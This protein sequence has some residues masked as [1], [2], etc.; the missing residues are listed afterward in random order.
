[1][2]TEE[3][4]FWT[5]DPLLRQ[6]REELMPKQ[7]GIDSLRN[8]RGAGVLFDNLA[9]APCRVGLAAVGFKEVGRPALLLA[10][11]VLGQFPAEAARK[12]DRALFVAF[13]LAHADLTGLQIDIGGAEV[14]E[15]SI[16]HAREEQQF[17]HDGVRE[18]AR[19]PDRIVERGQFGVCEEGGQPFRCRSST[20]VQERAGV[21]KDLFEVM[22]V[23]MV[24][25]QHPHQLL[26]HRFGR[27]TGGH[28]AASRKDGWSRSSAKS[29]YGLTCS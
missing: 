19:L 20:D 26:G 22:I 25:T 5:D 7:M 16:A 8:P 2:P 27:D 14:D 13:A 3:L 11:Q 28:H 18:L 6:I 4:E 12:E 10:L 17:E 23:G 29:P 24:G 9:Q 21:L 1:M 15:F